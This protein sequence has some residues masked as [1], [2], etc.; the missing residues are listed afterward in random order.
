MPSRSN[1]SAEIPRLV[2]RQTNKPCGDTSTYPHPPKH[3]RQNQ[4]N[5]QTSHLLLSLAVRLIPKYL[6]LY[7]MVP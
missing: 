6:T 3:R 2:N 5:K 1:M 7:G 4:K